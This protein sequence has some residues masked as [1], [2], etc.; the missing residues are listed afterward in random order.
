M[1]MR[2][3]YEQKSFLVDRLE[4]CGQIQTWHLFGSFTEGSIRCKYEREYRIRVVP[5]PR[6]EGIKEVAFLVDK[7]YE[8]ESIAYH[9]R[10]HIYGSGNWYLSKAQGYR[11]E[12]TFED[13]EIISR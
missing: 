5:D 12:F 9:S 11:N 1:G 7:V 10:R 3:L 4:Q 13:F 2:K 6:W 8:A